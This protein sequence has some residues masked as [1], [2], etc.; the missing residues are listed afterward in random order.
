MHEFYRDCAAAGVEPLPKAPLFGGN[1]RLRYGDAGA[2]VIHQHRTKYQKLA[3]LP[4]IRTGERLNAR[5]DG[6]TLELDLPGHSVRL[7]EVAPAKSP[8][9]TSATRRPAREAS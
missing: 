9:S 8:A 3:A 2:R 6:V 5:Q 7:L 1:I 4:R